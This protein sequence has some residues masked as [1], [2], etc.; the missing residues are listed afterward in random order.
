[1]SELYASI[2]VSAR[3]TVATAR[4]HKSTGIEAEVCAWTGKIVSRIEWDAAEN[5]YRF[6][7]SMEPHHGK[8]DT[9]ELIT[10]L[11]GSRSTVERLYNK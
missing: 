9:M 2:P 4:G 11:V 10:G 3:K 6:T 5:D 1:M 8:G 7:V